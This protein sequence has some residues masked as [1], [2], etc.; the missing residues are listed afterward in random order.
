MAKG[1]EHRATGCHD[2]NAHSS[3]SHCLLIIHAAAT[4]ATTGVRSV[5]KLT[6]CDLA[7]SERINKTGA[8]GLTLTEA[9]N[10]NRS[11]LELGNVISAL[12]QQSSHVPYRSALTSVRVSSFHGSY[13]TCAETAC[14]P[15]VTAL[16]TCSTAI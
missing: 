10:I 2:I 11:L 1:F 16:L 7:G 12:M 15:P 6:L 3:R 5:G 9:Q 13:L 14:I 8:T 4:D